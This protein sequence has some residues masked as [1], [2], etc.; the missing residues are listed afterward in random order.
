MI[1]ECY[2]SPSMDENAYVVLD[3]DTGDCLVVDPGEP[4]SPAVAR[5]A[6]LGRVKYI[7]LSHGHFDHIL[8]AAA[9]KRKTGA[10]LMIHAADAGML[11]SP[12]ASLCARFCGAGRQEPVS[13]DATLSGGEELPFGRGIVHV[14]HTPGHTPG[15]VCYRIGDRLMTGDTLF[16]GSVGRTDFEGGSMAQMRASLRKLTALPDDLLLLPGHGP[17]TTLAREKAENPYVA[18][19]TPLE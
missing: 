1:F 12:E 5:A 7:L 4:D 17:Q 14:I 10:L 16:R 15:S 3:E 8:G 19:L 13:P 18:D 6:A 9:C 11:S 2:P